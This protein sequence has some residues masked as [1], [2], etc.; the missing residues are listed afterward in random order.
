MDKD[1]NR[2]P[3]YI[4]MITRGDLCLENSVFWWNVNYSK[5]LVIKNMHLYNKCLNF[6]SLLVAE[7]LG[8]TL[9]VC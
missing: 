5:R 9:A 4:Q 6:T 8:A 3:L 2:A 1:A 7:L